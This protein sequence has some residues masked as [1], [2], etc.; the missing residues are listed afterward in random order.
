VAVP[1]ATLVRL[2]IDKLN[3][4]AVPGHGA[5]RPIFRDRR[6]GRRKVRPPGAT[7]PAISSRSRSAGAG[8][9]RRGRA[10]PGP[11]ANRFATRPRRSGRFLGASVAWRGTLTAVAP[12]S[13][14]RLPSAAAPGRIDHAWVASHIAAIGRARSPGL[15]RATSDQGGAERLFLPGDVGPVTLGVDERVRLGPIPGAPVLRG[16][17]VLTFVRP[18]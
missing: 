17:T 16:H 5:I 6:P 7:L 8:R 2:L 4:Q 18:E 3:G 13:P 10:R 1:A 12:R 9:V 15:T 11:N 14:T